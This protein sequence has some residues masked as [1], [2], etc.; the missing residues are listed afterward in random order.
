[1]T[2]QGEEASRHGSA[3]GRPRNDVMPFPDQRRRAWRRAVATLLGLT[4]GAGVSRAEPTALA[5]TPPPGSAPTSQGVAASR[6]A[7]HQ[8]I[9][10]Q[11]QLTLT[12]AVALAQESSESVRIAAAGVARFQARRRQAASGHWP[13]LFGTGS[14]TR[15][16]ASEFED[17]SFDFGDD[18]GG[19]D[20]L[21]ELPFGQRNQ[22]R[23][24]LTVEQTLWAAGRVA[25]QTA[26]ASAE[27][28]AAETSLAAA[29]AEV[30]LAVTEAYFDA[31]L[32]DRLVEITSSTLE[33]SEVAYRHTKLAFEVGNL[34]EFDVLRAQ[35]ARDNQR[36]ELLQRSADRELSY[37]RL[38]QLLGLAPDASLV[39]TTGFGELVAWP[40]GQG[41]PSDEATRTAWLREI[42]E[43]RSPVRAARSGVDQ[44]EQLLR[45][46]RGE[47]W[48]SF[49][50]SSDY[51]RVAYPSGGL[52]DPTDMRTNWTV[53]VGFRVPLFT[54]GRLA[55]QVAE[56]ESGVEEARARLD[57]LRELALLDAQEALA[58]LASAEAV[59]EASAG[60]AEQA[61][62][63][64]E[65]AELR[66]REG[67]STQ[68]ELSDARL[69]LQQALGNRAL[70]ARNLQVARA[71]VAL[72][73]DLPLGGGAP[74]V[75]PPGAFPV[76]TNTAP[77]GAGFALAGSG[78]R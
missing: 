60:T 37:L 54:G 59:W 30:E 49:A 32:F 34:S 66:Y 2:H 36:P 62:R 53:A 28:A 29:R 65:I 20:D 22:Y 64:Y 74:L 68:L 40:G 42:A 24:G 46:A 52:A 38:R 3:L 18:G 12:A 56:A 44:Q 48:P 61:Q 47:R 25:G 16:L 58:R 11:H 14:Y 63:A 6:G 10:A 55:G 70:A 13:Q 41:P 21:G 33:L 17:L 51:G 43:R 45:V 19:G 4:L 57:Q 75:P 73:P 78:G 69:L 77:A 39:L 67:L 50:L 71:R 1:M 31:M 76:P 23:L 15:T 9:L 35:V 27:L 7:E 72:L 26:A 8:V 5:S